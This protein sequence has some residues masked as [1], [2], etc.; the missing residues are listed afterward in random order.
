MINGTN[1]RV[2]AV[3]SPRMFLPARRCPSITSWRARA[4]PRCGRAVRAPVC[5][6]GRRGLRRVHASDPA[7]ESG[8]AA[9][10]GASP[11]AGGARVHLRK[12]KRPPRFPAG[13][14]SPPP[15][16]SDARPRGTRPRDTG[17]CARP[18]QE[19]GSGIRSFLEINLCQSFVPAACRLSGTGALHRSAWWLASEGGLGSHT[20]S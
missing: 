20:S 18:G 17:A 1:L 8:A 11:G 16:G 10:A 2:T 5:G 3:S 14:A 19:R 7:C 6:W 13:H 12:Q 9:P 15:C 4:A